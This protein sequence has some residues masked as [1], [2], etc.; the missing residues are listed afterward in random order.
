MSDPS[1][2]EP[3]LTVPDAARSLARATGREVDEAEMLRLALA[4]RLRMSLRIGG[5]QPV[6]CGKLLQL[7]AT[8]FQAALRAG[9]LPNDWPWPA[10]PVEAL[11]GIPD[12]PIPDGSNGAAWT[13]LMGLRIDDEHYLVL[14]QAVTTIEAGVWD[15][16]MIGDEGLWVEQAYHSRSTLPAITLPGLH[17]AFVAGPDGRIC[18]LQEANTENPHYRKRRPK[19]PG[20]HLD[21]YHPAAAMPGDS[22]LAVRGDALQ[23]L[24]AQL[25]QNGYP[26]AESHPPE[27]PELALT[28]LGASAGEA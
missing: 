9:A 26:A 19:Q 2:L 12:Y 5:P 28:I 22:T 11:L 10:I 4:G 14:S 13:W 8:D 16:P 3:W 24:E 18:Q 27:E 15:L 23:E 17:G 25:V 7:G 20:E 6:R 1:K 21:N